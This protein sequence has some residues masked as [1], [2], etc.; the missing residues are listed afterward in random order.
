VILEF[1][2]VLLLLVYVIAEKRYLTTVYFE[3]LFAV[4]AMAMAVLS[5]LYNDLTSLAISSIVFL[6]VITRMIGGSKL[7]KPRVNNDKKDNNNS[8]KGG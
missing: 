8:G 3:I 5:Y 2:S 1:I 6:L 4:L 7:V